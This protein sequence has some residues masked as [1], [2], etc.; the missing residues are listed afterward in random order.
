M[1]TVM[2]ILLEIN[3]YDDCFGVQH[4]TVL[5]GKQI[6]KDLKG[7]IHFLKPISGLARSQIALPNI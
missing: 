1:S 3:N 6:L 2:I 4:L 7:K 5:N